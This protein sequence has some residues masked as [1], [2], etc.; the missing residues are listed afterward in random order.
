MSQRRVLQANCHGVS[1]TGPL[2]SRFCL[3]CTVAMLLLCLVKYY[4]ISALIC[5]KIPLH[6]PA[7]VHARRTRSERCH[8][9]YLNG[10]LEAKL[11]KRDK[12]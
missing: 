8:R 5:V 7:H 6:C 12:R 10:F 3:I 2:G 9:R 1:A 4:T 11:N